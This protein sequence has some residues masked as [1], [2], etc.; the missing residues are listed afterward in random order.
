MALDD[1]Q[2]AHSQHPVPQNIMDVEFKLIGDLTMR[3][4][5]YLM[6]F[7][8]IAY[9]T[10]IS[11]AGVFKFPLTI[12]FILFG[13]ALA[14]VP[15][16]ERGMDEWF[17]NFF[18]AVYSP[19]QMIWKKET[20]LPAA[21]TY[22]NLALVKQELITL[23]PTSSRRKLE[24]YLEIQQKSDTQ[25]KLDIPEKEYILKVRQAFA[26]VSTAVDV[27]DE[28]EVSEVFAG[29]LEPEEAQE[30]KPFKPSLSPQPTPSLKEETSPKAVAEKVAPIQTEESK[31]T[32]PPEKK[33][34]EQK[35]KHKLFGRPEPIAKPKP[36]PKEKPRQQPTSIPD[37][38]TL[39]PIT[40]DRHAGRRFTRVLPSE[41]QL[42]LPVRGEKILKT[43]EDLDIEKEIDDKTSQLKAL[44]DQIKTDKNIVIPPKAEPKAKEGDG[45]LSEAQNVVKKVK[46]ENERLSNEIQKLRKDI[47]DS[48]E[49]D[50]EKKKK[51]EILD[52]LEKEKNQTSTN[53]TSLQKQILELQRR[54]KEQEDPTAGIDTQP[55][56][57]TY[58]KMQP[59]T[60][61]PNIVSGVVKNSLGE[62]Q[63]GIVLLI[64]NH[65]GESV[66][67]LKTNALGQFSIS[68]SLVNGLYT[69][70]VGSS[71]DGQ[72]F[73]IITVEV[74]GEVI[75]P[76]EIV[77]RAV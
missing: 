23:A 50:E 12:S 44:L 75:P 63:P 64:K 18:K 20:V 33:K 37:N 62:A 28:Q 59:I 22:Q 3:Q 17:V 8:L 72:T 40:P 69:I 13:L 46:E 24:E 76:I 57:P 15:I 47:Q 53:Y 10:Y 60:S 39:S 14:F 27:Y 55:K 31:T 70:E 45:K 5:T 71:V 2:K 65:K 56:Q 1:K 4:F 16:Q 30:F 38:F 42:I 7:G 11:A 66:R 26:P 74:K 61:D 19:S 41:G 32:L 51:Q 34:I 52:R 35:P 25:D 54:I 73:D 58:A 49:S 29:E 9:I 43:S 77:G 48:Q 36:K 68:T 21:F 67:A 6:V